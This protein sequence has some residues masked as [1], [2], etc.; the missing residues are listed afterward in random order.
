MNKKKNKLQ[1]YIQELFY[2]AISPNY[3]LS[4][5]I[6]V[7]AVLLTFVLPILWDYFFEPEKK[8]ETNTC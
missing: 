1:N 5:F 7:L 4:C 2:T 3:V 8:R 6:A